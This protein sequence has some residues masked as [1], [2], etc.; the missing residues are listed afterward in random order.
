MDIPI[1]LIIFVFVTIVFTFFLTLFFIRTAIMRR[2]DA[3]TKIDLPIEQ[4]PTT[5]PSA[6]IPATPPI[7][8]GSPQPPSNTSS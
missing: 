3:N 6:A 7:A 8:S 4:K 1:L 2:L 5:I